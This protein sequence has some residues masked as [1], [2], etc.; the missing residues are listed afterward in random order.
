VDWVRDE[1]VDVA[2]V[3]PLQVLWVEV[4]ERRQSRHLANTKQEIVEVVLFFPSEL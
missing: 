4:R 3:Q 1:E 2:L